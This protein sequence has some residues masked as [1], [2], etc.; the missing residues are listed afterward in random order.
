VTY[1]LSALALVG[2]FDVWAY[3]RFWRQDRARSTITF[4]TVEQTRP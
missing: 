3:R 1:F 2:A 4:V